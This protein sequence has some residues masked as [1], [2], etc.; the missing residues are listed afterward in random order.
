MAALTLAITLALHQKHDCDGGAQQWQFLDQD[1]TTLLTAASE[2]AARAGVGA[3]LDATE[4]VC[5]GAYS[6]AFVCC[7]PPG[8]H[9]GCCEV[10]STVMGAVH[11]RCDRCTHA[12]GCPHSTSRIP[13]EAH[14]ASR[15]PLASWH[16]SAPRL[17]PSAPRLHSPAP[18]LHSPARPCIS[19]AL[20]RLEPRGHRFACHGGCILNE[21]AVAVR[22]AQATPSPR[23]R[24]GLRLRRAR[25]RDSVRDR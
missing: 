24:P 17:H 18:R 10:P 22:H 25:V 8:H 15:R 12:E 6:G 14:P 1:E 20:E 7:R 21:T 9:C 23:L 4:A 11:P 2:S 16:P 13:Y 3:V 19:Q 5:R